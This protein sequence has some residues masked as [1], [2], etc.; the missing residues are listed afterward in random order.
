M[1]CYGVTTHQNDVGIS[2][3]N[4]EKSINITIYI[5]YLSFERYSDILWGH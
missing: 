4:K 2:S 5:I 1:L 3:K